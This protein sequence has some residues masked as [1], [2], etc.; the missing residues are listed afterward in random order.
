MHA[1]A[2]YASGL[3]PDSH[4]G[5]LGHDAAR[6]E[7]GGRLAE[8]R[9]DL[10]LERSDQRALAVK[11]VLDRIRVAPVGHAA[12]LFGRAR[13]G[14]AWHDQLALLAQLA[15]LLGRVGHPETS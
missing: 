13:G 9:G 6:H 10:L 15:A 14:E 8:Q 3:G 2:V 5:E 1:E 11:I 7:C 12:E 4:C